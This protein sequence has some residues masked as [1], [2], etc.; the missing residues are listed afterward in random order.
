MRANLCEDTNIEA[1]FD[2]V[3][4]T[5]M[6]ARLSPKD[7][8]GTLVICSDMEVNRCSD[9]RGDKTVFMD[10]IRRKWHN[11][12]NGRYPFPNLVYWNCAARNNTFIDEP[13]AGVTFVSG[14][15]P[16]LFE[17]VLKGVSAIQ[18]MLDKL[19]SERYMNIH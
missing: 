9:M 8:P 6:R 19:D 1:V 14:A 3:L 10:K 11:K 5:A 16:V 17:Q 18:L 13:S 12:C 15:S 2:L 4:D 7:I